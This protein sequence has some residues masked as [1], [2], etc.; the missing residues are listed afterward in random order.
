MN[1]KHAQRMEQKK[2]AENLDKMKSR[3]E[4]QDEEYSP[5]ST[6]KKLELLEGEYKEHTK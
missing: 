5:F 6:P 3:M 2:H 1:T 4:L